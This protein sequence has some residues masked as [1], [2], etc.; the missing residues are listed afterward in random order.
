LGAVLDIEAVVYMT[1]VLSCYL[2]HDARVG[3]QIFS[4]F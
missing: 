3:L 2:Q 1:S 4:H